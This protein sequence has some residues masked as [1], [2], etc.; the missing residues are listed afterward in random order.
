[1]L[2]DCVIDIIDSYVAEL[3]LYSNLPSKKAVKRLMDRCDSYVLQKLGFVLGMAS[4]EVMRLRIRLEMRG[5]FVFYFHMSADQRMHMLNVLERS[6]KHIPCIANM[7]W[8]FLEKEPKLIR[9]ED[10]IQIFKDGLFCRMMEYL[11][12]MPPR[13]ATI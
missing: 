13:H 1:M 2:P 4:N 8:I 3:D 9:H 5:E 7:T 10:Y 11:V 12:T 6:M